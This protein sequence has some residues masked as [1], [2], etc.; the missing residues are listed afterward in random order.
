MTKQS[1]NN[2][3]QQCP[4]CNIELQSQ[5]H[6]H[7]ELEHCPKCSGIF[8]GLGKERHLIGEFG[9][10]DIWIESQ[11]CTNHGST[12]K[13]SP[14]ADVFL[15]HLEVSHNK[16]HVDIL[17]CPTSAGMWMDIKGLQTLQ[18]IMYKTSQSREDYG[19]V[20]KKEMGYVRYAFQLLSGMPI[21]VWHP[22]RHFPWLTTLLIFI[23]A[24]IY[25]IE[26]FG[27]LVNIPFTETFLL[28]KDTIGNM[29]LWSLVTYI[30]LHG[31]LWHLFG[32]MYFL[33]VLG[34]NVED[35]IG[36]V[37]FGICFLLCGI[38]GG[39]LQLLVEP[40]N[41]VGA[42]GAIAGVMAMYLVYFPWVKFRMI[43]FFIPLYIPNT[44]FFLVWIGQNLIGLYEQENAGV[45][46]ACHIGG[47]LCGFVLA[48]LLPIRSLDDYL[49]NR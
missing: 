26:L 2:I 19:L 4:E 39:L 12:E 5:M 16:E 21:E 23:C 9:C 40:A 46:F 42:S 43:L 49:S 20:G 7:V 41:V 37:T 33:W 15:E 28:S 25:P 8:I 6:L 22:K 36:T 17:F 10:Q 3:L 45:A 27:M 47:F 18:S 29:Q 35:K 48:K 24:T 14:V 34:D 30:F 13:K 32:N 1:S 11:L 38:A 44:W 31:G